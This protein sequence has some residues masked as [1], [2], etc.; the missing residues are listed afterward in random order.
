MR[1]DVAVDAAV[2]PEAAWRWWT[3]FGKSGEV[4]TIDHGLG[5]TRRRVVEQ[6]GDRVVL[7]EEMPLPQRR[8]LRLLRHEIRLGE[9]RTFV[10]RAEKPAPF[11]A[12]WRFEENGRGGTRIVREMEVRSRPLDLFGGVG[13]AVARRMVERDIKAHVREM[14]RELGRG[15]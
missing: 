13:E 9:G 2:P 4:Q 11:E 1:V 14:E 8:G 5:K 7:E 3:D 10:E 15:G 12:R 6:T